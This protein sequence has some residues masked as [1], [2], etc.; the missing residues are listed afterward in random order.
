M[1]R[2][3]EY[4]VHEVAELIKSDRPPRLLDVRERAEWQI[5]HLQ[6]SLLLSEELLEEVLDKWPPDTPIV[7][8]CHHGVRSLNAALFLQQ[9]GFSDVASMR[10]GIDAWAREI[11]P[12][13]PRY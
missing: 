9:K 6:G 1:Q 4:S 2:P 7:C 11:D 13:L 10:G 8:L 3:K 5:V 12:H